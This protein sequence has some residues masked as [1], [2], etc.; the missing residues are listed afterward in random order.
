VKVPNNEGLA[1][2][3]GPE[4]C[5]VV[6]KGG[7]EALTGGGVGRVLSRERLEERGADAVEIAEGNISR[8]ETARP[9]RTPRGQR[10]RARIQ[11]PRTEAGRSHIRPGRKEI[12]GRI[13]KSEDTS[14]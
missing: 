13:G 6:R 14:R 10:P 2:H 9:G 11:A 4:S 3:I 8:V 12:P 7:G 1:S 5:A